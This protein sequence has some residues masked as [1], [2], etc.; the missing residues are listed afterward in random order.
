MKLFCTEHERNVLRAALGTRAHILER[1]ITRYEQEGK[2][3]PANSHRQE[4]ALV[5]SIKADLKS[6]E[7]VVLVQG[8]FHGQ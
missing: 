4:L 3:Q 7:N 8:G 2:V 5:Q 1:R 6:D